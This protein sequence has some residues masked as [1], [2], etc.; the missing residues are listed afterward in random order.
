MAENTLALLLHLSTSPD[1]PLPTLT[2]YAR[3]T[4][5]FFSY[6]G[7]FLIYDFFTAKVMYAVLAAATVWFVLF[8][9][10]SDVQEEGM[11]S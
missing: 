10:G 2:S 5:V 3:P 9:G 6:L 1:S 8:C 11:C 7:V 4:T